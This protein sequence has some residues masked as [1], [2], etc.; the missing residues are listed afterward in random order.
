M[1]WSRF[2]TCSSTGFPMAR[3]E[4]EEV[5][6]LAGNKTDGRAFEAVIGGGGETRGAVAG[7]IDE[8][9]LWLRPLE[10]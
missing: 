7:I 9:G 2:V 5:E 3:V 1:A 8:G 10:T 6:E 4:V